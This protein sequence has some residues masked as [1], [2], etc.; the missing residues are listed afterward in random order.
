MRVPEGFMRDRCKSGIETLA[1]QHG[2]TEITLEMAERGLE[3]ARGE[4]EKRMRREA[5]ASG[6]PGP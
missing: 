3:L 5:D 2:H 6:N 4:M 1:R